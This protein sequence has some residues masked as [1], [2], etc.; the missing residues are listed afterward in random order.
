MACFAATEP[1]PFWSAALG[2][3]TSSSLSTP[4]SPQGSDYKP[5][6]QKIVP[7]EDIDFQNPEFDEKFDEKFYEKEHDLSEAGTSS[8]HAEE[9]GTS[10]QHTEE[11][12][13]PQ[14]PSQTLRQRFTRKAKQVKDDMRRTI[15]N[16]SQFPRLAIRKI[17]R[18]KPEDI[19]ELNVSEKLINDIL[20]KDSECLFLTKNHKRPFYPRR[21]YKPIPL[22]IK[23]F[24]D[25]G[26]WKN[27]AF[28]M[29]YL[30]LPLYLSIKDSFDKGRSFTGALDEF[31]PKSKGVVDDRMLIR[32]NDQYEYNKKDIEDEPDNNVSG[33]NDDTPIILRSADVN[34]DK[35]PYS[36]NVTNDSNYYHYWSRIGGS[37][38]KMEK[39][40]LKKNTEIVRER[41]KKE[42]E[43]Q[44]RTKKYPLTKSLELLPI[45]TIFTNDEFDRLKTMSST[46]IE[47]C[48]NQMMKISDVYSDEFR[49]NVHYYGARTAR[50]FA[51]GLLD[52]AK[53]SSLIARIN[54]TP[55]ILKQRLINFL[56]TLYQKWK[57]YRYKPKKEDGSPAEYHPAA[58]TPP[59]NTENNDTEAIIEEI[60]EGNG[61]VPS[62]PPYDDG[63]GVMNDPA[64][65]QRHTLEHDEARSP[66]S[67]P[68]SSSSSDLVKSHEPVVKKQTAKQKEKLPMTNTPSS[69]VTGPS[70][71]PRDTEFEWRV[72][73]K[74]DTPI[75]RILKT[76]LPQGKYGS[77]ITKKI[78]SFANKFTRKRN[79]KVADKLLD[80]FDPNDSDDNSDRSEE[81][82]FSPLPSPPE[83]E[84]LSDLP[85]PPSSPSSDLVEAHKPVVKELREK[86]GEKLPMTNTPPSSEAGPSSDVVSS[87]DVEITIDETKKGEIGDSKKN[88]F[89]EFIT[90]LNNRKAL[91]DFLLQRLTVISTNDKKKIDGNLMKY[92]TKIQGE[93][94]RFKI[95]MDKFIK[96]IN[97]S[98]FRKNITLDGGD[99]YKEYPI[100]DEQNFEDLINELIQVSLELS[101][102]FPG[103]QSKGKE[104][105]S[106]LKNFLSVFDLQAY[107]KEERKHFDKLQTLYKERFESQDN[108]IKGKE[109][110]P[111]NYVTGPDGNPIK[112][113]DLERDGKIDEN[114]RGQAFAE[115]PDA[116]LDLN[117]FAMT[118]KMDT[119]LNKFVDNQ[120]IVRTHPLEKIIYEHPIDKKVIMA[121]ISDPHLQDKQTFQPLLQI[122][123][124]LRNSINKIQTLCEDLILK[125]T[126][127]G[128]DADPCKITSLVE[129][130]LSMNKEKMRT[131][132]TKTTYV[133]FAR[134]IERKTG[135]KILNGSD[136]DLLSE[137]EK[138]LRDSKGMT[139]SKIGKGELGGKEQYF[140]IQLK[141]KQIK[142]ELLNSATT[143]QKERLLN[144]QRLFTTHEGLL[145]EELKK[146][147]VLHSKNA[148]QEEI[149]KI[150][151]NISRLTD[152]LAAIKKGKDRIIEE[153]ENKPILTGPGRPNSGS[154]LPW[155]TQK[156]KPPWRPPSSSV[157]AADSR[158]DNK[159]ITARAGHSKPT[160][161]LTRSQGPRYTPKLSPIKEGG[162]KTKNKNNRKT[163][164]LNKKKLKSKKK[165][166]HKK[167]LRSKKK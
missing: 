116:F 2:R 92:I 164:K 1:T 144:A 112:V 121:L 110:L 93:L 101:K 24:D 85:P 46:Q 22:D 23:A 70:S 11:A 109:D 103:R 62:G 30:S 132:G 52:T 77:N 163:K 56:K 83:S 78:R 6:V 74:D 157:G 161:K 149:L 126:K 111:P 143:S 138:G 35:L 128:K 79:K 118:R 155:K 33:N 3:K 27:T 95:L 123:D 151:D 13:L 154:K 140:G 49:E 17:P 34:A 36:G 102:S 32:F 20:G 137:M 127:D 37:F 119:T 75:E 131:D 152:E 81:E 14:K 5:P 76:E 120:Y 165:L 15:K 147:N 150:M 55:G 31:S 148:S 28:R 135:I 4:K 134:E 122:Y 80:V 90:T 61:E 91:A 87:S 166:R 58:A 59:I 107:I 86:L 41:N 156:K 10:S 130:I 57:F 99:F 167:K 64:W 60:Y 114:A 71:T 108:M 162:K 88:K 16:R 159:Q 139:K 51:A 47:N 39:V 63:A 19:P 106:T 25:E 105:T 96:V 158:L 125:K 73:D 44:D 84:R 43:E 68:P 65:R 129:K 67:P 29:K 21:G 38:T 8:Q 89:N 18:T 40:I 146:L 98:N 100:F 115:G 97:D 7:I 66:P 104:S 117:K 133:K 54:N 42:F 141:P 12:A 82:P 94:A 26:G 113:S 142:K 69:S 136:A 124:T 160:Q 53:I 48:L 72:K 153:I 9:A 145:S 50:L 45:F